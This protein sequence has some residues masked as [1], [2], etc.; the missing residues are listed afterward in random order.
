[1]KKLLFVIV[2]LLSFQA[3]AQN[4]QEQIQ[5]I[6]KVYAEAKEQIAQNGKNGMA[7]LDV[8]IM[9][10][11]GT[12]V[13]EDFIINEETE[14]TF[15]FNKYRVNADL[16]YPD[17]SSCYFIT[18]NF[19]A[20][21]HLR[22][23]EILFDPNEGNLLFC[24]SRQETDAGF[25]F[26]NRYYYDNNGKLI[27]VKQKAG[28]KDVEP[29]ADSQEA[30]VHEKAQAQ[31]YLD[32]FELLMNAK[33]GA[34]EPSRVK[35]PTTPK[36]DRLTSI[37]NTYTQAKQKIANNDKSE[38]PRDM[39][40][41]IRDQSWG[42]PETTEMNF[43]FDE[44]VGPEGFNGNYCYFISNHRHHNNMGPDHYFEYLFTPLSHDLIFSYTNA[45]EEGEKYEWRYYYDENGK[46]IEVKTEAE[47]EDGGA[48]DKAQVQRYLKIFDMLVNGSH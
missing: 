28:G 23:R 30:S 46:C 48:A 29:D 38:L 34:S 3:Q 16:D 43:Y 45:R 40:I 32:A 36:A 39:T 35:K 33:G 2:C 42:P 15:Y 20:H 44:S 22:Y 14:L 12:Q 1:M 26:E 37:R 47:D 41:V 4:K 18:E 17:A 24:Y 5:Y 8:K 10:N 31:F 7:P 21:G 6:R 13:D 19:E 11:D 9:I 25:V 27:D